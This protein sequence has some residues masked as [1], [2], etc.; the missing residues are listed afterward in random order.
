MGVSGFPIKASVVG[1]RAT[2]DPW[3]AR[4]INFISITDLG[5]GQVEITTDEPHGLSI[6]N[7][8]AVYT[9]DDEG[10]DYNARS[11]VTSV[12]STTVIRAPLIFSS[13]V[14]G[15]FTDLTTAEDITWD[16]DTPA[17]LLREI[18]FQ[19]TIQQTADNDQGSIIDVTIDGVNF[20]PINNGD[21]VV[22]LADFSIFVTKTSL[23]NIQAGT[24]AV[25][26]L[27]ECIISAG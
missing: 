23:L 17:N 24:A 20:N 22:G 3:F 7:P 2:D 6:S 1:A 10:T 18:H 11:T 16:E 4:T 25:S 8:F 15:V 26:I 21:V 27:M 13:N 19:L 14:G 5:G 9:P 12:E